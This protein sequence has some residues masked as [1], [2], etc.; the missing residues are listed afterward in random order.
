MLHTNTQTYA[1]A[2]MHI[3]TGQKAGCSGLFSFP[4]GSGFPNDGRSHPL[5]LPV[6]HNDC[7]ETTAVL[8]FGNGDST[9][10]SVNSSP[11]LH[12]R[13]YRTV[14]LLHRKERTAS[15]WAH[16]SEKSIPAR[17]GA[18]E[19]KRQTYIRHLN[20]QV[21]KVHQDQNVSFSMIQGQTERR[22]LR[23]PVDTKHYEM[24][25][26]R[27]LLW[28]APKVKASYTKWK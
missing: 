9:H 10:L 12:L 22:S 20:S 17:A 13:T 1:G 26:T 2:H 25:S 23:E 24:H 14:F 15:Y 5:C 11:A 8:L 6:L 3:H 21:T 7:T 18:S 4:Y 27:H 16:L 19:R 28:V